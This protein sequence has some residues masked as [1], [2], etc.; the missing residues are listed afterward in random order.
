MTLGN[1]WE[2]QQEGR[3]KDVSPSASLELCRGPKLGDGRKG[4]KRERVRNSLLDERQDGL[5]E[6]LDKLRVELVVG[7]P[8][9]SGHLDRRL[10]V[11]EHV[12]LSR[13][14]LKSPRAAKES[15][16]S[17]SLRIEE[18]EGREKGGRGTLID[19]TALISFRPSSALR[20]LLTTVWCRFVCAR[21]CIV[22][23]AKTH[24]AKTKERTNGS[25]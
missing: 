12:Q 13:W 23:I 11:E 3:G 4:R 22:Q 24:P 14:K 5:E 17:V 25:T 2:E 19:L 8:R 21:M 15:G 10:Q 16:G 6:L 1:D 20:T 9:P 7:E 18:R